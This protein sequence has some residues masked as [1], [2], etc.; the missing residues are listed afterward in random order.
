ML[1]QAIAVG[2]APPIEIIGIRIESATKSQA[3]IGILNGTYGLLLSTN[4]PSTTISQAL[5]T[6]TNLHSSPSM[7]KGQ[8]T[9]TKEVFKFL[10][11]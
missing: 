6:Q 8:S 11:I 9:P 2:K 5:K 4:S 7:L 10:G 1:K 3:H